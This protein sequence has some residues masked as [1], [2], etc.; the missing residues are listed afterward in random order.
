MNELTIRLVLLII[1]LFFNFNTVS[2]NLSKMSFISSGSRYSF[3]YRKLYLPI[4]YGGYA[5]SNALVPPL[6]IGFLPTAYTD[7]ILIF[8]LTF[9][10]LASFTIIKF[11]INFSD[12]VQADQYWRYPS[13]KIVERFVLNRIVENFESDEEESF[14][15]SAIINLIPNVNEKQV[16]SLIAYSENYV[17]VFHH[18]VEEPGKD[19]DFLKDREDLSHIMDGIDM[20]SLDSETKFVSIGDEKEEIEKIGL[21]CFPFSNWEEINAVPR[22]SENIWAKKDVIDLLESD[23]S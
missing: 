22:V 8:Y 18:H 7:L 3:K 11:E 12:K 23:E 10:I 20:K 21:Y 14:R 2:K 13:E 15:P 4:A 1:W 17:K 19:A 6:I 16:I 5:I 9:C